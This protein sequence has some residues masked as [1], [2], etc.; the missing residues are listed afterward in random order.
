ME[1]RIAYVT[2]SRAD[3]GLMTPVLDA[4]RARDGLLLDVYV[5]GEHFSDIHGRSAA[6]VSARYPEAI[7]LDAKLEGDTSEHHVRFLADLQKALTESFISARPDV[8]I[9]LGDRGE[10]LVTALVATYL[11]IPIVHL[12]GG[13]LSSTLDNAARFAISRLAHLHVPALE[14]AAAR[15]RATGEAASRIHVVGA[16]ALDKIRTMSWPSREELFT[17]LGLDPVRELIFITQ[18]PSTETAEQAGMEMR[19]VLEAAA[20]LDRQILAVHPH[21]DPGGSAMMDALHEYRERSGFHFRPH[22]GHLDFLAV[23]RES[24]VWIGNSSAGVIE[25]ASLGVP[26]VNLGTRQAGRERGSNVVDAPIEI[27]AIVAAAEFVLNNATFRSRLADRKSPW[28]D[29]H[30]G[31]RVADLLAKTDFGTLVNKSFD[32]PV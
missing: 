7:L 12:H 8:V 24:A 30:T 21:L 25:S 32:F 18:H 11:R 16:P 15:L 5:A 1:K 23:A 17:R 10:Q 22:L 28:G 27:E 6:E 29:G 4:V 13:E 9:V 19:I 2:G 20:R 3:F 31:E 26:V 14:S